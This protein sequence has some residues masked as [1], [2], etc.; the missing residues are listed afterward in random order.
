MQG[1]SKLDDHTWAWPL[2]GQDITNCQVQPACSPQGSRGLGDCGCRKTEINVNEAA[3]SP[4]GN[5]WIEA[6]SPVC[7]ERVGDAGS[8]LKETCKGPKA[9]QFYSLWPFERTTCD[10]AR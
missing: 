7:V 8:L 4:A 1:L 5:V 6:K 2:A 3:G 9:V 10:A